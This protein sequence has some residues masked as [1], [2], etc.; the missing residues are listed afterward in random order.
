MSTAD[1]QCSLT[2]HAILIDNWTA[3]SAWRQDAS[4]RMSSRFSLGLR[5]SRS[6]ITEILSPNSSG[7]IISK[8]DAISMHLSLTRCVNLS[9]F[10]PSESLGYRKGATRNGAQKGTEP[11]SVRARSGDLGSEIRG[12]F[13]KDR[14]RSQNF[15]VLISLIPRHL[16]R[17]TTFQPQHP[18]V[19]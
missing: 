11:L 17:A 18:P 1:T 3:R 12:L 15:Q 10:A 2:A 6:K 14:F 16:A 19:S 13:L 5:S 9:T 7:S 4:R 8:T